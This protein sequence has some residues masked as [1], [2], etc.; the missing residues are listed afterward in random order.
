M[1]ELIIP[2]LFK[3]CGLPS[4]C[5]TVPRMLTDIRVYYFAFLIKQCREIIQYISLYRIVEF[6][7]INDRG[8]KFGLVISGMH[9]ES[10]FL[11][12]PPNAIWKFDHTPE[13]GTK[14]YEFL[15]QMKQTRDWV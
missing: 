6:T 12:L 13:T 3:T 9:I 8:T 4:F 11:T 15:Q 5:F 10:M 7:F 14:E 2:S 1:N